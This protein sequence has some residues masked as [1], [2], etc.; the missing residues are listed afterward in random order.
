LGET[1]HQQSVAN[2]D[3][4]R[5]DLGIRCSAT[6]PWTHLKVTAEQYGLLPSWHP[7]AGSESF[8]FVDEI[9]WK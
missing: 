2:L 7:G 5:L 4:F 3:V 1:T 6:G 9:R 8:I